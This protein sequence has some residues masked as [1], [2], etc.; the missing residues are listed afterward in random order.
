MARDN[1]VYSITAILDLATPFYARYH[2]PKSA[3]LCTSVPDWFV[4]RREHDSANCRIYVRRCSKGEAAART[5]RSF[6]SIC[7]GVWNLQY[8]LGC[9]VHC[10]AYLGWIHP[11]KGWVGY[12]DLDFGC[13]ER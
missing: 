1:W 2:W 3:S 9:R 10:R 12:G 13:A 11:G 5:L 7:S 8:R 6:G 4:Y